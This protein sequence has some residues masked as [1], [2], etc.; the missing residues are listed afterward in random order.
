MGHD[1]DAAPGAKR[2]HGCPDL[3]LVL[4]IDRGGRL[5][6]QD[7]R[8]VLQ[9][10]TGDRQTLA[11]AAGKPAAGVAHLGVVA[12]VQ[13]HDE[14]VA[15]GR[16]GR[17]DHFVVAH[18]RARQP[19][20]R[21]DA[22]VEQEGILEHDGEEPVP[23]RPG[24]LAQVHTADA[25][26]A[27]ADVPEAG[28][29][30]ERRR[31][32]RT[33][34]PDEGI[35]AARGQDE[36]DF[37]QD[38]AAPVG[39]AH[40]IELDG[41]ALRAL[42]RRWLGQELQLQ[43][44]RDP[45]H[46]AF[47]LVPIEGQLE[48]VG[49]GAIEDQ[50][51]DHEDQVDG[52]GHRPLDREHPA[53]KQ[54]GAE[55]EV[56]DG[57]AQ[58]HDRADPGHG[59][60]ADVAVIAHGL[61][62]GFALPAVEAQRAQ[63]RDALKVLYDARAERFS[64]G[65][66]LD[67]D[68]AGDPAAKRHRRQEDRQ[69]RDG[70]QGQA[71]VQ[72]EH[73]RQGDRRC[74]R[75]TDH[76]HRGHHEI[77]TRGVLG[78]QRLEH[79]RVPRFELAQRHLAQM[80]TEPALQGR[81]GAGLDP[82]KRAM[83]EDVGDDL[84]GEEG[85]DQAGVAPDPLRGE[86]AA[87]DI[88]Q[89]QQRGDHRGA[90]QQGFQDQQRHRPFHE[91]A[92]HRAGQL[93][94][95]AQG[96][97]AGR[98]ACLLRHG[99][100]LGLCGNRRGR[101]KRLD[102]RVGLL[103]API[104]RGAVAFVEA[105]IG[106]AAREQLFVRALILEPPVLHEE[107]VVGVANGVEAMCDGDH[108]PALGQLPEGFEDLGLVV[109]I[110]GRGRLVHH[111]HRRGPEDRAGDGHAL[112]LAAG[113]LSAAFADPRVEPA[114]QFLGEVEH[115]RLACGLDHGVV[116]GLGPAGADVLANAGVQQPGVLQDE[117]DIAGQDAALHIAQ[118]HAAEAHRALIDVPEAAD[119]P[120]QGRLAAARGADHGGEAA[121]RRAEGDVPQAA[122]RLGLA[123]GE[124]HVLEG[125]VVTGGPLRVR[126]LGKGLGT[127][128][129]LDLLAGRRHAHGK[130][131]RGIEQ[132]VDRGVDPHAQQQ[133]EH[134]GIGRDFAGQEQKSADRQQGQHVGAQ[135]DHHQGAGHHGGGRHAPTG[136]RHSVHRGVE[137]VDGAFRAEKGANDLHALQELDGR[138]AQGR[139]GAVVA[140]HLR[141]GHDQRQRIDHH[142]KREE[143]ERGKGKAPVDEGQEDA[144][145]Q[146]D[147]NRRGHVRDGVGQG[148][149]QLFDVLVDGLLEC[150]DGTQGE[151]AERDLAQLLDQGAA[152]QVE[153]LIGGP[154]R[155]RAGGH[156]ENDLGQNGEKAGRN[157]KGQGV[158]GEAAVDRVLGDPV[159]R[160]EG[161]EAGRRSGDRKK[162]RGGQR[163][164]AGANEVFHD[165]SPSESGGRRAVVNRQAPSAAQA[166]AAK[167][168]A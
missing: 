58:R 19:Q 61:V 24:E 32:A 140:V 39:E 22:V 126:R 88:Q 78:D 36:I 21:G 85:G 5:V 51:D 6:Q 50:A 37:L 4:R 156:A 124:A 47:L 110:E 97:V 68:L 133:E 101:R 142:Q 16:L 138:G 89:R 159:D 148:F 145:G 118:V 2:S 62:Q 149:F 151:E 164:A 104:A 98:E 80:P 114:L 54:H 9:D 69:A 115:A 146:G 121:F 72:E 26:G 87:G 41:N 3:V 55:P 99:R 100:L 147:R 53:G 95:E 134:E 127:E 10:G 120:G 43:H 76:L 27:L 38:L 128:D 20:V 63:R 23:L 162:A 34:R 112:A 130:G 18:A 64:R 33:R 158:G 30:V 77:E 131:A 28:E 143:R 86:V 14:V 7:D 155:E 144:D 108:R 157:G 92:A 160:E 163:P 123:V 139:Q 96:A 83:R 107:D 70:R 45:R 94:E 48:G 82:P 79:A 117:A 73:E 44:V 15:A 111:H 154:V 46:G 49:D 150:A 59:G 129:F 91:Q 74:D 65:E 40:A 103:Q 29:Q 102:D 137:L 106:I 42:G 105:G 57:K 116:V 60:Q 84:R 66:H 109:R 35:E 135:A 8:R 71:P 93:Q 122:F 141:L 75:R 165:G 153:H 167:I 90:H 25:D 17:C 125:Q 113:K 1:D 81:G 12:F 56:Q 13:G 132:L 152:Q 119:Q 168:V 166:A 136:I 52:E 31:L 11:L 161:H 67:P